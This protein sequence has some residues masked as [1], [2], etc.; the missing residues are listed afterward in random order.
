MHKPNRFEFGRCIKRTVGNFFLNFHL[1]LGDLSLSHTS[2]VGSYS[3]NCIRSESCI[4]V[5]NVA[6]ILPSYTA[7]DK[8]QCYGGLFA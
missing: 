8:S 4:K 2:S 7:K 6:R 1:L 3:D 5:R